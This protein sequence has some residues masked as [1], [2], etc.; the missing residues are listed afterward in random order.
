[1]TQILG[2]RK[3]WGVT[4]KLS[5]TDMGSDTDIGSGKDMGCDRQVE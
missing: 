5:D 1:M 4:D 2:K 3:I